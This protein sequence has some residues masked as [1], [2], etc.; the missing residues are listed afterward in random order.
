MEFR[1]FGKTGKRVFVLGLG[2]Y[3]HGD[4]YGGITQENSLRVMNEVMR[5]IPDTA[6]FII[7]TAPRYA[8]GKVEEWVGEFIKNSGRKNILIVTKGGRHIEPERLNEKDFSPEFLKEDLDNSLSRLNVDKVFLYL[9]HNPNLDIVNDGAVFHLLESFRNEGKI[10]WYGVSIDNPEEGIAAIEYCEKNGLE[11]L[12]AIQIIYNVLQKNGLDTLF[13]LAHKHEV[14]II[15]RETL[16]RGFL[17]DK[18]SEDT[19]F[20]NSPEAVKKQIKLYGKNQILSKINELKRILSNQDIKSMN[21]F[22]I[23]FAISNSDVTLAIPGINRSEYIKSDLD[24]T[25]LQINQ[26]ILKEIK[27][28][29]DLKKC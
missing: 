19:N 9:L 11:G 28:I 17:T 14:A 15:A 20:D 2:T 25:N 4:V 24:S 13:Q 6:S 27:K 1:T 16:L 18:Y 29:S 21:Q 7:D 23:K 8:S 5:N 10:E 22:A 3:G 12:A 26:R